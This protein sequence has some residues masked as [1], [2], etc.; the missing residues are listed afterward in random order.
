MFTQFAEEGRDVD[1]IWQRIVDLCAKTVIGVSPALREAMTRFVPRNSVL[2]T[3]ACTS[4]EIWGVDV[5]LDEDEKPWLIEVNHAPSFKGGTAAETCIKRGVVRGAMELLSV[6]TARKKTL[7]ARV[8]KQW[9]AYMWQTAR[10]ASQQRAEGLRAAALEKEAIKKGTL[11]GLVSSVTGAGGNSGGGAAWGRADRG[12]KHGIMGNGA[13]VV[14]GGGERASLPRRPRTSHGALAPG[15]YAQQRMQPP[16]GFSGAK[17][18]STGR[19]GKTTIAS[20]S[21]GGGGSRFGNAPRATQTTSATSA[22]SGPAPIDVEGPKGGG[23][24]AMGG[25][26]SDGSESEDETGRRPEGEEGDSSEDELGLDPD[27]A[28]A[29]SSSEEEEED[30]D[31]N[32]GRARATSPAPSA[33]AVAAA[34]AKAKDDHQDQTAEVDM[35]CRSLANSAGLSYGPEPEPEPKS[36]QSTVEHGQKQEQECEQAEASDSDEETC[37]GQQSDAIRD[38]YAYKAPMGPPSSAGWLRIFCELSIT[39]RARFDA[40]IKIA[41]A[42]HAD[43]GRAKRQQAGSTGTAAGSG[44]RLGAAAAATGFEGFTPREMVEPEAWRQGLRERRQQLAAAAA[45]A[46]G[47]TVPVPAKKKSGERKFRKS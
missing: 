16:T 35:V 7:T 14:G 28:L 25:Y 36:E 47:G 26:M 15:P 5:L 23:S 38:K 24:W 29:A 11:P 3:S 6:S 17:K 43:G 31:S 42:V 33:A 22:S 40:A 30:D 37:E 46:T 12:T 18:H 44:G 4:F 34:A 20:G 10:E 45:A 32:G 27:A 41:E 1:R 9:A 39:D 21:G 19:P 8:R 13:A 2:G